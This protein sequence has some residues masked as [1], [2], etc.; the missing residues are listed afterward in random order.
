MRNEFVERLR[1]HVNFIA[2]CPE[3]EIG[4]GVPRDR[5]RIVM[6]KNSRRLIQLNTKKDLTGPMERF[7]RR[8]LGSLKGVDGFI[9]KERSPSCDIKK[10]FFGRAVSKR[11]PAK[12]F[13]A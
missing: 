6:R 12:V 8:Y 11:F 10:G 13:A 2:V 7:V 5:I 9:L 4:L 3:C 1:P